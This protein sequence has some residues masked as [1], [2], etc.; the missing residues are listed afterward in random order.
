MVC[1]EE[2]MGE[3]LRHEGKHQIGSLRIWPELLS[4]KE[5]LHQHFGI[6]ENRF[7]CRERNMSVTLYDLLCWKVVLV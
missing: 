3:M 2:L 5:T 4:L 6:R 7:A 1:L